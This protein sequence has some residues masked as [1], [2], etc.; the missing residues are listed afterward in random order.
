MSSKRQSD[1]EIRT[2][3]RLLPRKVG[4]GSEQQELLRN[5]SQL[6]IWL[7]QPEED[8]AKSIVAKM[9]EEHNKVYNLSIE[10]YTEKRRERFDRMKCSLRHREN[11]FIQEVIRRKQKMVEKKHYDGTTQFS[12]CDYVIMGIKSMFCFK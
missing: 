7:C 4:S 11:A 10:F 6:N 5:R 2:H 3:L 1:L 12:S 8:I 9:I